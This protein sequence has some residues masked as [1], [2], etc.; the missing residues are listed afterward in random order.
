[1]TLVETTPELRVA[2][3]FTV[4]APPVI[5]GLAPIWADLDGDG[6]REIL[7]TVSGEEQGAQLVAYDEGGRRV[8]AGPPIGRGGRWRHQLAVASFGP[9]G[10]L[11]LAGV[12]TPH[13]G[14][15]VEFYAREGEQL[16]IVAELPGYSSHVL[17]ARNLDMAL[18]ADLDGDGGVELLVPNQALDT[19]AVLRRTS[20]GVEATWALP[21]D[22][23]VST[24]LAAVAAAGGRLSIGVGRKD[25]VLRLWPARPVE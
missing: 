19:L 2:S 5:E 14:G 25:G 16:R 20:A 18:A 17:G 22:G 7:V 13:L 9:D 15:I 12:R 6:T 10:A 11:E 3:V 1:V 8:A 24:N 4:D 21:V 23:R